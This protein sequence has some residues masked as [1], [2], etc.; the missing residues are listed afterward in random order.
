MVSYAGRKFTCEGFGTR[1]FESIKTYLKLIELWPSSGEKAQSHQLVSAN[2]CLVVARELR[3]TMLVP[4]MMS[5]ENFVQN[6]EYCACLQ[7]LGVKEVSFEDLLQSY[8][9]LTLPKFK[10]SDDWSAYKA[11]MGTICRK[12]AGKG[13]IISSRHLLGRHIAVDNLL[14]A[15]DA[16]ELFDHDDHIF[17]AAFRQNPKGKFV[18]SDLRQYRDLWI[19]LGM[20]DISHGTIKASSYC[21]CLFE[22][23]R[24]NQA[25][26]LVAPDDNLEADSLTVLTPLITL[27]SRTSRI[28]YED[29][30]KIGKFA[31]FHSRTDMSQE[32]LHRQ[33][34]M[35]NV[36]IADP[37]LSLNE[38]VSHTHTAICWTQVAFPVH[39]PTIEVL[40]QFT[41]GQPSTETVWNHLLY[42]KDLA[43]NLEHQHMNGFL[44]DLQETYKYLQDNYANYSIPIE[45]KTQ[46]IWLNLKSFDGNKVTLAD[47]Q[48]EWTMTRNL[49]LSTSSDSGSHKAVRDGLRRFDILLK[50]MGCKLM[51][52]PTVK[53]PVVIG[54]EDNSTTMEFRKMRDDGDLLDITYQTEGKFIKAHR[55]L[56]ATASLFCKAHFKSTMQIA[57]VI[58]YEK[59]DRNGNEDSAFISYYTLSTMIKYAYKDPEIDWTEVQVADGDDEMAKDRKLN[60]LIDL[61]KGA[62]Y[63]MMPN[64]GAT[65]VG[66]ILDAAPELIRATNVYHVLDSAE[67]YNA[68]KVVDYCNEFIEK[69]PEVMAEA[70]DDGVEE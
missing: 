43:A 31:V 32:P 56:L 16:R 14:C 12:S 27:N 6:T 30:T 60:M 61:L 62:D 13:S 48:S 4:W 23:A 38:I 54:N 18:H 24:R 19:T 40:G 42:L 67:N 37:I 50:N 5:R 64:L 3:D 57:N 41:D 59:Y 8:Q 66:K 2:G 45:A 53:A 34:I 51:S 25:D 65:V 33:E 35:M 39:R 70:Y 52:Y 29:W 10:N 9:V 46:P 7:E 22:L 11:M 55:Q 26:T 58:K 69:N 36:A 17:R 20:H 47:V 1:D 15:R 28:N 63:W 44:N 68:E 49:L 21:E